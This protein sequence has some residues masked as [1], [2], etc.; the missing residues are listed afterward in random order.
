MVRQVIE[1]PLVYSSYV[2]YSPEQQRI[3][4]HYHLQLTRALEHATASARSSS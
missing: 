3:S 2:W 1:L 4:A